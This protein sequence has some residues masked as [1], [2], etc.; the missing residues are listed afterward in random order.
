MILIV[1]IRIPCHFVDSRHNRRVSFD[2]KKFEKALPPF[3]PRLLDELF[4]HGFCPTLVGGTVRDYFLDGKLGKDWDIELSHGTVAHSKD[5]WKDFGKGLGKFGKVSFL[6][7]DVIRL[8]VDSY[9]LEFSP[10]RI[11]TFFEDKKHHSNFTAEFDYKLPFEKAILRRDFTINSMGIRF[12]PGKKYELLDPLNGLLDLRD[13]L[14]NATGPDFTKDPVRFLRAHRFA[15]K[16]GFSFSPVL[17]EMLDKMSVEGISAAYLWSETK[18]SGNPVSYLACLVKEGKTHLEL[19]LPLGPEYISKVE[20]VRK[21]LFDPSSHEAWVI[22]LEWVGISADAWTTY[23]NLSSET[24]RR[25]ARWAD[26]SKFFQN[27]LP[28]TFQGEFDDLKENP[29]FERLFDWY[30][31]TKQILQKNPNLPILKMIEEYLPNWIHLYRFEPPKDV[32]HI[33]PPL[34]AK[35]QVWNLCQR[36]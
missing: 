2:Q 21:I 4:A 18:K 33:D 19:K 27:A 28:E 32:K 8:E 7:Y 31:T 15:L 9:Q 5:H 1:K 12:L 13:K 6:S 22:A 35:Y 36:I 34:R 17:K 20:E 14:L 3:L 23:F 25:L 10:P 29:R 24:C 16:F 11:E 26:S 30:F